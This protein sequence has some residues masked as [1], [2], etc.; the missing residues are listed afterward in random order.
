VSNERP[1]H[2]SDGTPIIYLGGA[3]E[4][5]DEAMT[6]APAGDADLVG[7]VAVV[8]ADLLKFVQ[9]T[10]QA[11][12]EFHKN[13]V[14][15]EESRR[16][17]KATVPSTLS[18]V[19]ERIAATIAAERPVTAPVLRGVVRTE[20]EK[21]N[22]ILQRQ[23]KSLQAKFDAMESKSKTKATKT[24]ARTDFQ[25]RSGRAAG[26]GSSNNQGR[27]GAPGR[28][29]AATNSSRAN[30]ASRSNGKPN[31]K[32]RASKNNKRS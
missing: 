21:T 3:D 29:N 15:N 27:G 2:A 16:I 31:G 22:A 5:Q 30:N 24:K 25:S 6:D 13:V 8:Q 4:D 28:G 7:G 14:A 20:A 18:S 1:A 23:V 19:S 12:A 11:V 9:V 10:A 32:G 17:K 26:R